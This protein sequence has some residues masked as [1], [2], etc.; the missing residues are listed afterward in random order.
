MLFWTKKREAGVWGFK[1]KVS[2]L[3]VDNKEQTCGKQV[4]AEPLRNNGTDLL[5]FSVCHILSILR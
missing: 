5:D 3:Q 1:R 4:P 2:N